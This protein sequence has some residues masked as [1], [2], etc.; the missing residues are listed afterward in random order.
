M[1][2]ADFPRTLSL[3]DG[4]GESAMIRKGRDDF[5]TDYA[6]TDPVRG[7]ATGWRMIVFSFSGA[8]RRGSPR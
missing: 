4:K 1:T 8:E 6:A 3:G 2:S 7:H 5:V